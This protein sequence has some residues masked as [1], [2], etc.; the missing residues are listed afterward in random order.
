M[1]LSDGISS[2]DGST[3]GN[4]PNNLRCISSGECN[5]CKLVGTVHE[6]CSNPE[7]YCDDSTNPPHCSQC[8]RQGELVDVVSQC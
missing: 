6:G 4:C 8:E 7:P 1:S 3:V 2:G 5:V